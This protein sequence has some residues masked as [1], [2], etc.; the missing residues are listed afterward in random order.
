MA[1][2][3]LSP[4]FAQS[5]GGAV[6]PTPQQTIQ[7]G[8]R[9]QEER[10]REQQRTLEPKAD[11]LTPDVRRPVVRAFP[12]DTQC[13]VI[14]EL[15]LSESSP[16]RF[17][18][19]LDAALPYL[20]RCVGVKGLSFIAAELD[21]RLHDQGYATTRV[22]LP[23]Q[24]LHSGRLVVHVN[25][26]RVAAIRMVRPGPGNPPD[27]A[28]GTWRN[29]FPLSVGDILDLR[30]LEQG[31]ENMKK[32]PSQ[33]VATR[34]EPGAQPG[35]S[36]VYI[37]RKETT[38][39]DRVRGGITLDNSG[40]RALG[41]AQL[42]ASVSVDNPAGL[43][44][45]V[46]LGLATNVRQPT[47]SHRSQSASAGY[48]VPWGYNLL[49]LNASRSRF[50]QYVQGTTVRFLSSGAS[51]SADAKLSRTLWRTASS[52]LGVHGA[53]STRRAFSYLDD[54]E[55]IIQR[56]RTTSVETGIGY[57]HLFENSFFEGEL[58]YR[59]GMPWRGAQQ[60]LASADEG[61]LTVRP[62][63]WTLHAAYRRDFQFAGRGFQYGATLRGQHTRNTTLSVD[64]MAIGG[65]YSVRG[66]D[67][68]AVL[69][70]ENGVVLRNDF[71]TPLKLWDG[72]QTTGFLAIDYGRVWG[73]SDTQL[74][75]RKLVGLALGLKGRFRATQFEATLATPL[76]HPDA[77]ASRRL[78]L[79]LTLTQ[80]I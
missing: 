6:A 8:L 55:V 2:L 41:R 63:L 61:G 49:S 13:F 26:G 59:R 7:E 38:L 51:E 15:S 36:V 43:N 44:D 10:S 76:H 32:L 74:A 5:A 64:Q 39:K 52:K 46:T 70:A 48:T 31:V 37:E 9:R 47:A 62:R 29:A 80:S 18:W 79:Y 67:G 71:T 56:R 73:P 60:D 16:V 3:C 19:L 22:G 25:V 24:S 17:G 23:P 75:G 50:A 30:A 65:R 77:F 11:E 45:M 35:S 1:W 4:A 78:N 21:E 33:S 34:L 54:T 57:E 28:W 12:S 20:R 69:L 42:Q 53:V 27:E 14:N 68:D 66:F 58:A 72:L 40:S